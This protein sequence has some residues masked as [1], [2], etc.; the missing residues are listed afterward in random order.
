VLPAARFQHDRFDPLQMQEVREHQ[1]GRP[2]PD[3]SYLG[4]HEESLSVRFNSMER[5]R[6]CARR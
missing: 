3:N 4:S 2:C 5:F 6:A 1:P